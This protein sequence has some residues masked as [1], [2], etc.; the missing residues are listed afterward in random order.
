[1]IGG[2]WCIMV[3][4]TSMLGA[5]VV[6]TNPE[7][8]EDGTEQNTKIHTK[9]TKKLSI[10]CRQTN[11]IT[12]FFFLLSTPLTFSVTRKMFRKLKQCV[13]AREIVFRIFIGGFISGIYLFLLF[14]MQ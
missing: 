14:Q 11:I 10:H 1:M 12:L 7:M 8:S 3:H 2:D 6:K 4:G 5:A 13:A 9:T